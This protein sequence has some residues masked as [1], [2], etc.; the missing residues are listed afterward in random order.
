MKPMQVFPPKKWPGIAV[1]IIALSVSVVLLGLIER[2]PENSIVARVN[3]EP[4]TT[5]EFQFHLGLVKAN[6]MAEYS[7]KYGIRDYR[8]FWTRSFDG[9]RPAEAAKQKAMDAI[10]RIK[11]Q[12]MSALKKGIVDDISFEALQQNWK[13]ENARRSEAVS[14]GQPVYGPRQYD[15]NGYF[16]YFHSNMQIQLKA[17]LA[18]EELMPADEELKDY[19]L[20]VR[21]QLYRKGDTVTFSVLRLALAPGISEEEKQV[22]LQEMEEI[23][24]RMERGEDPALIAHEAEENERANLHYSERVLDMRQSRVNSLEEPELMKRIEGASPGLVSDVFE[25]RHSL[26]VV[27]LL[28]R[29]DGGYLSYEE[30]KDSV[31]ASYMDVK[32]NNW[33]DHLQDNAELVIDKAVYQNVQ[34]L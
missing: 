7:R 17:K 13:E 30:V 14:K 27:T 23:R 15:M 22:K 21:D 8:N 16:Q 3:G 9:D 24:E 34:L 19:Y 5:E 32:Y 2:S 6:V 12:E 25:E 28:E 10:V 20:S 29:A 11:L 26:A 4:V 1:M 18:E 33:V 31:W